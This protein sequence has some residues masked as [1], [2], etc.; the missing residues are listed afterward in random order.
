MTT[1]RVAKRRRF[2]TVDR[3]AINDT[4]LSFKARGILCWLLDKPDD[5]ETTGDRIESQGTEGREAVASAL[6]ELERLGY[7]VRN[8]ERDDL[9]KW[10][11]DWTIHER[12]PTAIR[13]GVAVAGQPCPGTRTV[14]TEDMKLKTDLAGSVFQKDR[15][16]RESA[17]PAPW[18]PLGLTREQYFE[19]E[20]AEAP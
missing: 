14:S 4:R 16:A 1:I 19:R 13:S 8:R 6:K 18:I 17:V 3:S 7:L 20:N 11:V 12:P 10:R 9:G 15:E 2:T 5:W